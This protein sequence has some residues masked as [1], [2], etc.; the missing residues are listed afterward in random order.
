MAHHDLV[1]RIAEEPDRAALLF[2]VDG[3]LAPIVTRPEDARVPAETRREL[4]RLCGRYAL[5]G[6]I[7]G[8]AGEDARRIVGVSGGVY[9]GSHGLE[10]AP[11]AERWRVLLQMFLAGVDWPAPATEN[12]GLTASLHYREAEDEAAAVEELEG[13]AERA[14]AEGFVARFGRKVLEL[15]P[16]VDATKG[17]AVRALLE[18]RGL[19]RALYAG[20]DTTDLD[21]FA[22][23]DGLD[24][25]VRVAMAS[26]EGPPALRDAA[27]VVLEEPDE[28]LTLLRDL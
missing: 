8:R 1:A 6:F 15:L 2:D 10:L 26:P 23:L 12:K 3:T 20:D 25:A 5:V 19:R 7:S 9:V 4:E 13:I 16:P 18:E 28:L 21:A 22:A 17:T 27:D 11:A 24:V 14:R